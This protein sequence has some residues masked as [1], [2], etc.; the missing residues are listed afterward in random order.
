VAASNPNG[1]LYSGLKVC[2]DVQTARLPVTNYDDRASATAQ[3]V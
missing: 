2:D 3:A 1:K